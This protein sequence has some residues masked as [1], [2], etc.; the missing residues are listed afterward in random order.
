MYHKELSS[1]ATYFY[2]NIYPFFPI[3]ACIGVS[4][5]IRGSAFKFDLTLISFFG[6]VLAVLY[7]FF[8][9]KFT[10]V[11]IDDR[12]IYLSRGSV[13]ATL[14]LSE[15]EIVR[16]GYLRYFINLE[17]ATIVFNSDT[18]FGRKVSFKLPFRI[19]TVSDHPVIKELNMIAQKAKL[20][21]ESPVAL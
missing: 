2:R 19:F 6:F 16:N 4:L 12:F 10:K 21:S 18:I 11:E 1:R 17:S 20:K 3:L 9:R 14:P 15:I 7:W 5:E 13:E 8:L